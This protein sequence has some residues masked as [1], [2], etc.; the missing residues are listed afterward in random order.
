[1]KKNKIS[2]I[3]TLTGSLV[4]SA[5]S[6]LASHEI[7][8]E[9]VSDTIYAD[10]EVKQLVIKLNKTYESVLEQNNSLARK[11]FITQEYL[12][13]ERQRDNCID[14]KD[15]L[16]CV[17]REIRK[18][19]VR[20]QINGHLVKKPKPQTYKCKQG[21]ITAYF[22]NNTIVSSA[23]LVFTNDDQY[24]IDDLGIISPSASGALY[25]G[26]KFDF[27]T[28]GATGT[29]IKPSEDLDSNINICHL[30]LE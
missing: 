11:D 3:I 2:I 9:D 13:W 1:M 21:T 25:K 16:E 4:L 26:S 15:S 19:I 20:L 7:T 12:N 6:S 17:K 22:F 29:L 27:W 5:C 24:L 8:R 30:I 14:Q 10:H 18:Q 28:K 23:N